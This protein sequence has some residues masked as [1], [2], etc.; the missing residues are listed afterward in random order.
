MINSLDQLKLKLLDYSDSDR[1]DRHAR[2][3]VAFAE[4]TSQNKMLSQAL[5][6]SQL[7]NADLRY[8]IKS[9]DKL[10]EKEKAMLDEATVRINIRDT[11][12]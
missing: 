4:G 3:E 9:Y 5:K 1:L 8:Q 7:E 12:G 10:F 2:L 11:N 6:Q